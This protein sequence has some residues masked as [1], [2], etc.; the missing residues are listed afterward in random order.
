MTATLP[1]DTWTQ[2]GFR[3][4][5]AESMMYEHDFGVF[6]GRFQPFHNAHLKAVRFALSKVETLVL[7]LGSACQA[8][9]VKNPWT[10]QERWDMIFFS[11]TDEER[12]R[13]K[14][15]EAKDYLY[16]DNLWITAV[17]GKIAEHTGLSEDIVLLGH[18][19]DRSSFYLKLF[20][21]WKFIE[22]PRMGDIDA[23]HV[24][25][26]HFK[27]DLIGI[28]ELVPPWVYSRLEENQQTDDFDRLRREYQHLTE[29]RQEWHG[30]PFS[31]TFVTVD[32]VVIRSGHVLVV[33]RGGKA[34]NGLVALPGGF[35]NQ[36]ERIV[37]GCL[38]ELKEE[39]G[40]RLPKDELR[41]NITDQNVFDHPDRD[42]RGRT[43]TH[44][45]CIDLGH[46]TLPKVKG[47][48]D[49]AKA[50]WMPL[51]DL[52]EDDFFGDHFHIIN[53]FVSRF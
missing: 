50:W 20:P 22:V 17:Q 5:Q 4:E 6:I 34:G 35:L 49:A 12:R 33:R 41:K 51:R 32:A 19:K 24:R 46:G 53:Y 1:P 38:R 48:D 14:L 15:V 43:I 9:T 37:D 11:L 30:A 8:R 23:T 18:K 25:H 52:N 26:M 47:G 2:R 29:Y 28:K 7:V 16:N 45:Y 10:T 31:P 13:I 44:A 39:T 21:Q 42:L 3:W 36:R 40:I 27:C